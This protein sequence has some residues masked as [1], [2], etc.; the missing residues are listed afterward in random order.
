MKNILIILF[1]C[2]STVVNAQSDFKKYFKFATFYTAASGGTSI[3]DVDEYSIS[4]GLQT[5]IV[6]TPLDMK[7]ERILFMM[8]QNNLGLMRQQ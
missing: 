1:L 5:S 8:E 3:S 6:R 4:N 2:V 7:I